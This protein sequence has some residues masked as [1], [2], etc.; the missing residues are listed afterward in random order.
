MKA[1]TLRAIHLHEIAMP[2]VE[3]LKTSFGEE[4]FKTAIIA[5]VQTEDGSVGW[6]ECST[7]IN[8]GYSSE[9][10]GTARHVLN[11]FV[12]PLL[13]GKTIA[14]PTDVPALISSVRGHPLAKHGIEAAVWDAWAKA[15]EI[16]LAEA[17]AAHLPAGHT[18]RGFATVGVSIG[19]KPSIEDT[20]NTIQLRTGQGYG[21]IKLKIKPGWDVELARG[22]RERFPNITLMLDANS[23]YSLKDIE[24][25]KQ[26]DEFNLLMIEQPLGY[27]DIYEHSKL[28]PH[29]KT[30]ICLDESIHSA[31]DTRLALDLGACRIINLKPGRV[32]GFS[33]SLEIYKVCAERGV[34]LWVGGMLETGIGRAANVAFASLPGVTL[35]CDISATDRY[36]NPDVT[37]PAFVLRP[38]ST[39]A[40][41]AGAGIGVEVVRERLQTASQLWQQKYPYQFSH[42]L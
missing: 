12:A 9:T 28:Q 18:P 36:F 7:E 23:A 25:L 39:L 14:S 41:A 32:G 11:E 38:D 16:G 34:P 1:I 5:E 26:L 20:C 3:T 27:T 40:T 6:G 35:P 24:H 30:P 31:D 8:P 33:E 19:I 22:V 15:N 13:L 4:P 29:L 21:R 37:E 10:M 17:F 2:L 42:P